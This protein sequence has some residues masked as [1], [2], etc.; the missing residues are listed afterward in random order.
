MLTNQDVYL[1]VTSLYLNVARPIDLHLLIKPV[2][3]KW[4]MHGKSMAH[5]N[6]WK[7]INSEIILFQGIKKSHT[8]NAFLSIVEKQ[9]W[10]LTEASE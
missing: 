9:A 6:I 1:F 3:L 10:R 7:Y 4:F 8:L 5:A 2:G